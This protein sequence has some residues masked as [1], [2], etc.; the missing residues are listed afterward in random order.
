MSS[1]EYSQQ[2]F[3]EACS[4]ALSSLQENLDFGLW[5]VTKADG[6]DWIILK[7]LDRGYGVEDGD[8]FRWCDSFCHQMVGGKGPNFAP[9]SRRV[10]AYA[11][12]NIAK[13]IPIQ[14]YMG[15]P[16]RKPSG[17]LIGT[18][19]AINPTQV[20]SEWSKY[21][22][23][24]KSMAAKIEEAF[25]REV[26]ATEARQQNGAGTDLD[27]ENI[28]V[29]LSSAWDSLLLEQEV[30]ARE[31][32][33][34]LSVLMVQICGGAAAASLKPCFGSSAGQTISVT[35]VTANLLLCF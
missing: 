26:A 34:N 13:L 1:R 32:G 33:E 18:L 24:A 31:S 35:L 20:P 23:Y 14:A 28:Q 30:L 8:V 2:S 7:S 16:L 6:E 21:E 27:Q 11:Q 9:D 4:E 19:C 17:E 29:L 15:F 25:N 5:M 22:T 12:A 10:P 3:D